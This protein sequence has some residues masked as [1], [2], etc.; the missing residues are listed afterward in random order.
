MPTFSP[1]RRWDPRAASLL[2][3]A[4]M[5][6]IP[7]LLP[8]HFPPLRT[9]YDE[10]IALALGAGAIGLASLHR[11][12][13]DPRIPTIALWLGAFALYLSWYSVSGLAAYPQGPLLWAVYV[14]FAA[15]LIILGRD[16]KD[17]FGQN[18]V[19]D[20]IAALILTGAMLNA[21]S[22]VLQVIG[23]PRPI[24]AFISYL[25]GARATGNIGQANLYV[26]YLSLGIACVAYQV[27]RERIR[28]APGMAAACLLM[29]GISLSGSRSSM[30]YSV[31]FAVLGWI[32]VLRGKAMRDRQVGYI[33]IVLGL[34]SILMQ[35]LVP[36]CL[37]FL[38]I[39]I[40]GSFERSSGLDWDTT[41]DES[42]GL[43][44]IAWQFAIRIFTTSPWFGVGPGEFAGAGFGL[45]LPPELAAGGIWT[46]PHNLVLQLLSETGLVGATL[47][48]IA[49]WTWFRSA[50]PDFL[51]AP[52]PVGWWLTACV[53]VEIL[54][55]LLE[56]PFWY[57]HFLALAA[58][59][60]GISST[61]SV[62]IRPIAF[63]AVIASGAIGGAILLAICL[64]DYF[65][66]DLA[67][68]I[69]AG[70]SLAKDAEFQQQL[71]TLAGLRGGLLAPRAELW[72]F[73]SVPITEIAIEEKIATGTRVLRT[74]PLHEVALRQCIFLALAGRE[75]EARSLLGHTL[76]TFP[77]RRNAT[78]QAIGSAP[79]SAQKILESTLRP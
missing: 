42:F 41:K 78:L 24:D 3:V 59:F 35:W 9:F 17:H 16:L 29:V 34:T 26:N 67:S 70:R 40:E 22:G 31:V 52:T 58:L 27:A 68:P 8:R 61:N 55:A 43:R 5:C 39:R 79:A 36:I 62:G 4:A 76:K 14:A 19:C 60:L 51:R 37:N 30:L 21:I 38:G 7:F 71:D 54:H 33:A 49:I 47:V 2:L 23:I 65:R 73:L 20:M 63:R 25:S 56:Y 77:K 6:C 53:S 18:R 12:N 69:Y 57:A 48:C 46:S 15:L 11:G 32:A 74:W 50:I 64:R 10:W 75:S 45:G 72:W 1:P 13:Q 28:I 66:F 44:L